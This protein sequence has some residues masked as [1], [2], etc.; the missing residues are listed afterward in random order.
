MDWINTAIG[1]A[2]LLLA[3]YIL[4]EWLWHKIKLGRWRCPDCCCT[5]REGHHAMCM[6]RPLRRWSKHAIPEETDHRV[7]SDN[8]RAALIPEAERC[9]KCAGTGNE[10]LYMYHQCQDC[11]GTGR[12]L[13]THQTSAQMHIAPGPQ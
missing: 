6:F 10:F 7:L 3:A 11:G 8:A 9:E 12:K 4:G 2:G 1:L 13:R 5:E